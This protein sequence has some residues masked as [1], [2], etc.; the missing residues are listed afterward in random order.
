LQL[1][2]IPPFYGPDGVWEM[3]LSANGGPRVLAMA[4]DL[5]TS[6]AQNVSDIQSV[7]SDLV[8][9]IATAGEANGLATLDANGLLAAGQRW[10]PQFSF[11]NATDYSGTA[12]DKAA[13]IYNSATSKWAVT[14]T[15]GAWTTASVGGTG[16]SSTD[17]RYRKIPL[18]GLVEVQA[19][20]NATAATHNDTLFTLPSDMRP[21]YGGLSYPIATNNV[22]NNYGRVD[23]S[24]DGTVNLVATFGGGSPPLF[25]VHALFTP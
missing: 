12:I 17:A 9:F 21:S 15:V 14:D 23:I 8:A 5:G 20:G 16:L 22:S 7:N 1:G 25:R 24:T 19:S 11:A 13:L 10:T 6:I 3:W 18:L 4:T 2:Q